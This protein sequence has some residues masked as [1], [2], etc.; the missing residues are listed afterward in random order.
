MS[1]YFDVNMGQWYP[2]EPVEVGECAYCGAEL[3]EG[4]EVV[5]C[6]GEHFCDTACLQEYLIS[7]VDYNYEIL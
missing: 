3:Y 5:V 2:T 6:D 1:G 4:D 7:T